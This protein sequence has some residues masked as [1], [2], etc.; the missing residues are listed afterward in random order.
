MI[1]PDIGMCD[2][3]GSDD[4]QRCLMRD[5][6]GRGWWMCADCWPPSK[7]QHRNRNQERFE[8]E[9]AAYRALEEQGMMW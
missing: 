4:G 7:R 5:S 2:W 8:L 3:C 9:D 1:D 6:E